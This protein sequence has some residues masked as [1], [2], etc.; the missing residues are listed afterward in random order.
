MESCTRVVIRIIVVL[1]YGG[2]L[3]GGTPQS[4][5]TKAFSILTFKTAE[6]IS[7]MIVAIRRIDFTPMLRRDKMHEW[8]WRHGAKNFI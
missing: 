7:T 6:K 5:V 2:V 4:I 8:G 1:C 3:L